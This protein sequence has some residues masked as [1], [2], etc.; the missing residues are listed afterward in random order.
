MVRPLS[1]AYVCRFGAPVLDRV[2]PR[3]F[4]LTY[5]GK[6]M[7]CTF[8]HDACCQY[9]AD[10]EMPRVEALDKIKDELEAYMKVPR[11]WWF[12]DDPEDV[13][14]L[15][16]PEYPGGA[17]TRTGVTDLPEGRS[18]HNEYAC[19]F[20]DPAGRGCMIHRFALERGIQ[21]HEIKPLV[22]LLFPLSFDQALLKPAYEFEVEDLI[23]QGPG[24]TLY[25]SAKDD[26][27]WYFGEEL[28]A[29]LD[30]MQREF[31]PTETPSRGLSLP[32][33]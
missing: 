1:R 11:E 18:A 24:P 19:V 10:I 31:P 25:E 21:V 28:V 20:L 14:I 2:D 23:C 5:F 15:P 27:R 32:L 6:C 12:R 29:E 13:G 22:C 8:C 26:V 30:A 3:I 16:E 9:G 33:T 17:Y 7:D 4:Q